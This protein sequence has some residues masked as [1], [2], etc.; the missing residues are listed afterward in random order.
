[1]AGNHTLGSYDWGGSSRWRTLS[2]RDLTGIGESAMDKAHKLSGW[3]RLGI[4][5]CLAWLTFVMATGHWRPVGGA[6]EAY[7]AAMARATEACA[8]SGDPRTPS[9]LGLTPA[10]A[11][12]VVILYGASAMTSGP[13]D[14]DRARCA[15]QSVA[16]MKQD[17]TLLRLYDLAAAVMPALAWTLGGWAS[18]AVA[19][20][21][22]AWIVRGF[23]TQKSAD[24]A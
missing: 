21:A 17:H 1:M 16:W 5:G 9:E 11:E 20:L 10:E 24:S 14:G 12:R 4:V 22:L 18:I 7:E 2:I 15:L 8:K 19:L 3:W 13:S 23:R 6:S